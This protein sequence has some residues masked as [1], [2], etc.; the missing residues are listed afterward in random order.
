MSRGTRPLGWPGVM[1]GVFFLLI[2]V[3]TSSFSTTHVINFGGALGFAY[4]PDT[5][6]VAVGD[7]I[8]WKGDFSTHPLS[9]TIIPDGA[10]PWHNGTGTLFSYVVGVPGTY[11][12]HCDNHFSLGMVGSFNAAVTGVDTKLPSPEPL[13]Y[14]L[15]QNYPNPFNPNTT[16]QFALVKPQFT[17]L[18]VYDLLGREVSTLVNQRLDAGVHEIR[19]DASRLFSGVYLYQLQAGDFVATKKL[20]LL[21]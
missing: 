4:S 7:T 19:F 8:Q 5:L 6:S 2:A 3:P 15:D 11:Q 17:I 10:A 9:S 12:Y 16:I 13:S 20:V 14:R 21:R 18:K 1:S